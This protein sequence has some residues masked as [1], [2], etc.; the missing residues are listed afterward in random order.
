VLALF[1]GV[2]DRLLFAG[3]LLGGSQL[4]RFLADLRLR[5]EGALGEAERQA[6][7]FQALADRYTEGSLEGL[8]ELHR[9][10]EEPLFREEAGAIE[11][12]LARRAELADAASA[13]SASYGQQ[14][15]WLARH[16]AADPVL[17]TWQGFQPGLVV[18][19]ETL[20]TALAAGFLA[21]VV[22]FL[23]WS[24]CA[25]A[26]RLAGPRRGGALPP[27]R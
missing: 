2:L 21:S 13:L 19:M 15:W 8:V 24:G 1:R 22:F 14:L 25:A 27:R 26:L 20:L 18:S 4:P 11:A 9:L 16:R 5:V 10:S 17:E 12:L 6:A 7:A 3:G 23:S